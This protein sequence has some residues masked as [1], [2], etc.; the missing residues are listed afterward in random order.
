MSYTLAIAKIQTA[1]IQNPELQEPE[2]RDKA[3]ERCANYM[4]S[5]ATLEDTWGMTR[6]EA[7]TTIRG[8][9]KQ[10][11]PAPFRHGDIQE[12]ERP[13]S[14]QQS[15]GSS[16]DKENVEQLRGKGCGGSPA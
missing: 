9:I 2:A 4:M 5:L 11:L 8:S 15:P 14:V 6:E 16:Q 7:L 12:E 1:L 13:G 10:P 3:I